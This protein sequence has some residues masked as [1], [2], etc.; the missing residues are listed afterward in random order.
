MDTADVILEELRSIRAVS[1]HMNAAIYLGFLRR[2]GRKR[3][4]LTDAGRGLVAEKPEDMSF[5]VAEAILGR[6]IFREALVGASE[7]GET[8]GTRGDVAGRLAEVAASRVGGDTLRRRAG[9]VLSWVRWLRET[10]AAAR[11]GRGVTARSRRSRVDVGLADVANGR[12]RCRLVA[13][14]APPADETGDEVDA[15]EMAVTNTLTACRGEGGGRLR[16][17]RARR[18][19][20]RTTALTGSR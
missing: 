5:R 8:M 11:S 3:W 7:S 15:E 18:M 2:A 13:D 6:R 1:T 20:D 9:T 19:T 10:E 4:E 12:R 16:R 17:R 14:R